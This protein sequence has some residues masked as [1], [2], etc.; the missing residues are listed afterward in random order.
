MNRPGPPACA[1]RAHER[2]RALG[3]RNDALP[4]LDKGN[5]L[6]EP[7][8]PAPVDRL[9]AQAALVPRL[10]KLFRIE[11]V[12]LVLHVQQPAASRAKIGV[13]LRVLPLL[14]AFFDA[15]EVSGGH[16]VSGSRFQ[17]SSLSSSCMS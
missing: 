12:K 1:P 5:E 11:R 9:A 7:P 10:A 8:H 3:K 4:R 2:C 17:V 6:A 15:L 14:A 13:L 16:Q